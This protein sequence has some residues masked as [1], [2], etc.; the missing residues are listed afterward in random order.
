VDREP[1][2]ACLLYSSVFSTDRTTSQL[3][4]PYLVEC[5]AENPRIEWA[6]FPTLNALNNPNLTAEGVPSAVSTNRTALT[7]PGFNIEVTYE[8]PGQNVSYNN[9]Y[10]T[11]LGSNVTQTENL[12]CVFI[13][14]LNATNVPFVRTGNNSGYCTIPDGQVRWDCPVLLASFADTLLTCYPLGV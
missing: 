4:S 7:S 2:A 9:S 13:A 5:P 6:R 10:T 11:V 1:F 8:A 14:Q 3:L 12:T